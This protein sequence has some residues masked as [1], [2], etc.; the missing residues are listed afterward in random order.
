MRR[1]DP[2]VVTYN[3][4]FHTFRKSNDLE[5]TNWII[6]QLKKERCAPTDETV[7]ILD[8][9]IKAGKKETL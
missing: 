5:K 2:D 3:I 8:W 9:L 1:N 7:R 6:D 4:L